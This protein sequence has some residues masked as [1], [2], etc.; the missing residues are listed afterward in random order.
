MP[1]NL[2]ISSSYKKRAL[3]FFK[4]HQNIFI[5]YEKTLKILEL[6][7]YHPSLRLHKLSGKLKYLHSISIDLQYRISIEFYIEDKEI[8]LINI[9]THDEVY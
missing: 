9:G 6:D 8:I 3:K 4:R 1:Y 7:P 5:K 2:T